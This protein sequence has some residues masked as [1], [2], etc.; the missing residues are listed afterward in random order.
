MFIETH[1]QEYDYHKQQ[2]GYL[3]DKGKV[4]KRRRVVRYR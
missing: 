1:V 3:F 2:D 4:C